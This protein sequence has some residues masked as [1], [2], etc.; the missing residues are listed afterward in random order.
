MVKDKLTGNAI[1]KDHR[2]DELLLVNF[3]TNKIISNDIF[4]DIPKFQDKEE[5]N[6]YR[7]NN[8]SNK[9]ELIKDPTKEI[10]NKTINP[11]NIKQDILNFDKYI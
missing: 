7:N 4:A 10:E 2:E 5:F 1:V 9:Y 8:I 11:I 3:D 6:M